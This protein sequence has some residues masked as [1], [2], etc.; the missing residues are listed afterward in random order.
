MKKLFLTLIILIIFLIPVFPVLADDAS[1]LENRISELEKKLDDLKNQANTLSGQIAYY[2]GQISLNQL[3]ITQTEDLI[4]SISGKIVSLERSLENRAEVLEKQIVVTYKHSRMDPVEMIF[5][6][7]DFSKLLSRFKYIQVVQQTSRQLM[8]DTQVVQSNY[9]DQKA[10]IQQ[11]RQRL[12]AQKKSLASLRAEKDTLLKQTKNDETTYQRLLAEAIAEREAFGSFT[13]G[14][15]LLPPQPSPDGWYYNQRDERWG[16]VCIG[17]TCGFKNPS[18]VWRYGCLITSITMLQKKN[19]VDINP[20]QI[21]SR[22]EY[23]F[24]DLMLLPWPAQPGYK[25]TRY[26]KDMSK[27]DSELSA[28]RP[29]IVELLFSDRSQH[30]VVFKSKQGSDYIMN[31]PWFGPD[32]QFTKHYSTSNIRSIST[33]TKT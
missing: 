28:G 19:G 26:A 6:A 3:K 13:S 17:S 22:R 21:A 31:D 8:H 1:D 16:M 18:Y 27:V 2:D 9:S 4:A 20:S 23:F 15:G 7:K 25:F 33:Y 11:S 5:S 24:Q 32:L 12:E 10:L 14:G 30:F 29:V